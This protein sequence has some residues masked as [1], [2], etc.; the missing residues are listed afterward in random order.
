MTSTTR[1][2]LEREHIESVRA[3]LTRVHSSAG[4]PPTREQVSVIVT[5]LTSGEALAVTAARTGKSP[6]D[7]AAVVRAVITGL[8]T[9]LGHSR[10]SVHAHLAPASVRAQVTSATACTSEA[11]TCVATSKTKPDPPVTVFAPDGYEE[12]LA[13]A[14]PSLAA[15][16]V[17]AP[18]ADT[19]A[20]FVE[21]AYSARATGVTYPVLAGV[22]G[23]ATRGRLAG[24]SQVSQAPVF[25]T[26]ALD[27]YDILETSRVAGLDALGVLVNPDEQDL[28]RLRGALEQARWID[29][30]ALVRLERLLAS[31]SDPQ[32]R[33][34]EREY[35]RRLVLAQPGTYA[36]TCVGELSLGQMKRISE[37]AGVHPTDKRRG[38]ERAI[39]EQLI[40]MGLTSDADVLIREGLRASDRGHLEKFWAILQAR[41]DGDPSWPEQLDALRRTASGE[42]LDEDL[43]LLDA[44]L[45]QDEEDATER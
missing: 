38:E 31:D 43:L 37:A 9:W 5:G 29:E 23:F 20:R 1:A 42:D 13:H 30:A 32:L 17:Q 39:R 8:G 12:I 27:A 2:A 6:A 28:T 34:R 22:W 24:L 45:E 21:R 11:I 18:D 44:S 19:L 10:G 15:V 16:L 33:A 3:F 4:E 36:P 26:D 40:A 25:L 41:V 14:A 7:G 35:L